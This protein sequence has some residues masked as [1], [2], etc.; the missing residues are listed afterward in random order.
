ME[1]LI[2]FILANKVVLL[3]FLLSLSEAL[4]LVPSI[5]ANSIFQVVVNL[6]KKAVGK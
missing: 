4:A 1:S 2:A 6:L 3:V 5:K